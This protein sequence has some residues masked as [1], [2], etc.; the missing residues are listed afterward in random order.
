MFF[1]RGR[2]IFSFFMLMIACEPIGDNAENQQKGLLDSITKNE[3]A[4]TVQNSKIILFFGNSLTA[5]FRVPPDSAF[6]NLIQL[7]ID[8]LGLEHQVI[9]SGLT[10]ETTAHGLQRLQW[11]LGPNVDILIIELGANDGLRGYDI[12]TTKQNLQQMI[13]FAKA[14]NPN[15]EIVLTGMEVPPRYGWDYTLSFHQIYPDL[16]KE[17][18]VYLI[19][20]LLQN[21][22]GKPHL[23]QA[24][25]VHPTSEGHQIIAMNV[26]E[27]LKEII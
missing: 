12:P 26:W 6:P 7:K 19:P 2:T 5:G 25:K 3:E 11:T 21:V 4:E 22:A 14:K 8:S 27:V 15:I 13:D 23:N 1:D 10:G 17:N 20:F 9:S 24:D 18:N 16:A